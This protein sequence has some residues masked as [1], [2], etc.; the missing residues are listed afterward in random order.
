MEHPFISFF[1]RHI[2]AI[3]LENN[4]N[5]IRLSLV[6]CSL[7][8]VDLIFLTAAQQ[9]KTS[10]YNMY[11]MYPEICLKRD[12]LFTF[13]FRLSEQQ[14]TDIERIFFL[15]SKTYFE[16]SII[17]YQTIISGFRLV[18]KLFYLSKVKK[19]IFFK[20]KK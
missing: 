8:Q 19:V 20:M 7:F 11:N 1:L 17:K 5:A 9:R 3:Q 6:Y 12:I 2:L 10:I 13:S 15:F 14:K 18:F 4:S 16:D